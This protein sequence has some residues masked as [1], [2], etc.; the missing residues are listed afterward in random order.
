MEN[1]PQDNDLHYQAGLK[2]WGNTESGEI[3]W[4]GTDKQWRDYENIEMAEGMELPP[5]VINEIVE[6][7]ND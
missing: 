1:L 2:F 4:V 6:H 7:G 3:E 5:E